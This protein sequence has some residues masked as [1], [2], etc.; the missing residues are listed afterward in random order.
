MPQLQHLSSEGSQTSYQPESTNH[1]LAKPT[2][3]A[4]LEIAEE[5]TT[6]ASLR[7]DTPHP[8]TQEIPARARHVGLDELASAISAIEARKDEPVVQSVPLGVALSQANVRDVTPEEVW[9]EIRK[10][11][12]RLV[13]VRSTRNPLKRKHHRFWQRLSIGIVCFIVT[14]IALY[15]V[16][17]DFATVQGTS[18]DS[19][20]KTTLQP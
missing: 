4:P 20:P 3:I 11:R 6:N 5:A 19:Q 18:P 17:R 7:K 2:E 15:T 13:P 16:I 10:Q 12:A 8:L 1:S 9:E 14:A